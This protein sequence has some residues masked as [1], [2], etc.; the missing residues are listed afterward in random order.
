[1]I[2]KIETEREKK[3]IIPE[4]DC[5][6]VSDSA[7]FIDSSSALRGIISEE[8]V[9]EGAAELI[10]VSKSN[11]GAEGFCFLAGFQKPQ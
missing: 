9:V 3:Y 6:H 8:I 10:V 1:M 11:L 5:V 2:I 4:S 7:S